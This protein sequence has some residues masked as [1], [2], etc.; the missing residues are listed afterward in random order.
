MPAADKSA[1][2]A[3]FE[4]SIQR[5]CGERRQHL[6]DFLGLSG[7]WSRGKSVRTCRSIT[8]G[9]KERTSPNISLTPREHYAASPSP[10]QNPPASPTSAI[11]NQCSRSHVADRDSWE[12]YG[13]DCATV[14][15]SSA[16]IGTRPRHG[17]A[18]HW[19]RCTLLHRAPVPRYSKRMP[20]SLWRGHDVER[21]QRC[22]GNTHSTLK[23]HPGSA[24]VTVEL[25]RQVRC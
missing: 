2:N 19:G 1:I 4:N 14:V 12:S 17:T 7:A 9:R 25:C 5:H 11:C 20:S 6:C 24:S 8:H 18:W 16:G 21:Q 10:S 13:R 23:R 22:G 3:I 15:G